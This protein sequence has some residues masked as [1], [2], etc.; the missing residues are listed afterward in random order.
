[1]IDGIEDDIWKKA[2]QM[3]INLYIAGQGATGTGQ[4]LWDGENLYVFVKVRDKL[5]SKK[6]TNAYEQD[7]VEIFVDE[8]NNKSPEYEKDDAQYRISFTGDFSSRGYPAKYASAQA[9]TPDGY[10]VE[11]KIPFQF[12]KPAPGVK[13]GFDLQINDDPGSGRRESYAKWNDPTNESFRNTAGFGTLIL[14]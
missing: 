10:T 5:L 4:A 11:V 9:I 12:I 13:I 8:K 7:S 14:E 2:P 1:V 6:S 3:K